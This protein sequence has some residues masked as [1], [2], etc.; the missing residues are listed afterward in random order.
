[1][2]RKFFVGGLL[3]GLILMVGGV[4]NAA[5]Q[6]ITPSQTS[7]Q[8]SS[9]DAFSFDV[10]YSNDASA[11]ASGLGL[12]MHW[13]SSKLT[14]VSLGNLLSTDKLTA[15]VG[16]VE[17]D[18]ADRDGDSATDKMIMISWVSF[19]GAW[20]ATNT[21]YTANFTVAPGLAGSTSIRFSAKNASGASTTA[22]GYTLSATDVTV[23][24]IILTHVISH[25]NAVEDMPFNFQFAAD[26]FT[27]E[28]VGDSLSYAASLSNDFP[29]PG[30]LSFEGATRTFSGT[31]A[32]VDIGPTSQKVMDVFV[33][34]TDST[35]RSTTASFQ[36]ILSNT[37]DLP[38]MTGTPETQATPGTFYSFT[39]NANDM[40][41]DAL[42]FVIEN[43]PA[44][45]NFNAG[46]GTLSGSPADEHY[47][48]TENIAIRLI[49]GTDT[50]TLPSFD[51]TVVDEVKP[52]AA[53]VEP[54]NAGLASGYFNYVPEIILTCTDNGSGCADTALYYTLDGSSP[55]DDGGSIRTQA[56][57]YS[58]PLTIPENTTTLLSFVAVDISGNVSVVQAKQYL[59]DTV[60]PTIAVTHPN[61][62]AFRRE[63]DSI[64]GTATDNLAG[65]K[66]I[67]LQVIKGELSLEML[68]SG[69][70]V[71]TEESTWV[72]VLDRSTEK[73]WSQ[74]AFFTNSGLWTTGAAY[75]VIIQVTDI[76]DNQ[77]TVTL[78]FTITDRLVVSGRFHNSESQPVSKVTVHFSGQ[79]GSPSSSV[80]SDTSGFYNHQLDLGW[81]GSVE[82]DK[83]GYTF[84]PENFIITTLEETVDTAD[85]TAEEVASEANARAIIVAGGGDPADYL[86][87]ATNSV[88]NFAYRTLRY[89]GILRDNIRYF[90]A[91]G[92]QDVDGDGNFGN[93][94]FGPPTAEALEG[95]IKDWA[96]SYVTDK[97]PLLIY[98]V[99]H[100]DL[101]TFYVSKPVGGV[102]ET[103]SASQ[104]DAWLDALQEQTGAKVIVIYDACFSGSFLDDLMPPPGARRVNIMSTDTNQLASFAS[105]GSLSFSDF[106]WK[107]IL[108]GKDLRRSFDSSRRDIR[109]ATNQVQG[110]I[111]DADGDGTWAAKQEGSLLADMYLGNPFATAAVFPE[112]IE[113]SGDIYMEAGASQ[114]VWARLQQEPSAIDTVWAV[115][116]PPGTGETGG[117]PIAD[118][119]LPQPVSLVY[120]QGRGQYE[121]TFTPATHGR[122]VLNYYAQ[123]KDSEKWKSLP[124]IATVHVGQDRF[125]NDD[126]AEQAAIITLNDNRPQ[127]HNFHQPGDEDWVTFYAVAGESYEIM[128]DHAGLNA[129]VKITLYR[130]NDGL[131]LIE[132]VDDNYGGEMELLPWI[133]THDGMYYVKIQNWVPEVTGHGTDYDL[134]IY[135]PKAPLIG[136]VTGT[137]M[138][139]ITG[140][141][142]N[143][144][145]VRSAHGA[146]AI[147]LPSGAFVMAHRSGGP[148]D[149]TATAPGYQA[150]SGS[151]TVEELAVATLNVAMFPEG[152]VPTD[153]DSDTIPDSLDNCTTTA[154]PNQ[155]NFDGDGEGD[156][157]D[158]DDDN[159]GVADT[160]DAYPL[161]ASQWQPVDTTDSDS[162]GIPDSLD[163]CTTTANP[164][165]ANF[166]GDE[167]GDACDS[168]DDND[169]VADR[170]DDY[171]QDASRWFH[172]TLISGSITGGSSG[173]VFVNVWSEHTQSWG[174][175]PIT[176]EADGSTDFTIR[177]LPEAGDYRLD[178]SSK[179][180][181]SGYYSVVT[182]GPV[183]RKE[184][185]LLNTRSGDVSG[186]QISLAAATELAVTVTGLQQGE[187]VNAGLWSDALGLGEWGEAQANANGVATL[188]IQGLNATGTDYRLFVQVA[189]GRYAVGHYKGAPT[190]TFDTDLADGDSTLML[191]GTLVDW[192]QATLIDMAYNISVK[193]AVTSGGTI[194]GTVSGLSAHQSAW[195]DAYSERTHGWGG[196]A[197]E[198]DTDGSTPYTLQGIKRA[199]DY[200]VSI[201]GDGVQ[202]GFY[203]GSTTPLASWERAARIDIKSVPEGQE[204]GDATGIDLVVSE[205]VSISGSVSGLQANEWAF[206]DAWSDS[207]FSWAGTTVEANTET[208]GASVPYTL[209]GLA[210][211]ADYELSLD[212]A[213]YV[214]QRK[215]G[216]DATT[217]V[218]GV[219]FTL[220]TGGKISGSIRGLS[221]SEFVWLDAFSPERGVWGGVGVVTDA[222][223]S[224]TYTVDGLSAASDYVVSLRT[225]GKTFF[226]K[227]D[228]VTPVWS[229]HGSVTVTSGTT[230]GIDFD[231]TSAAEMVFKLSGTVT[232]NPDSADQVVEMMAWSEEG[233]VAQVSR[234][235]GGVFTLK[236]LP[237]GDYMLEIVA[238]GYTPQRIKT[239]TVSSGAVDSSTLAW[240]NSWNGMGT[241]ALTAH[242]TGLDVT[243]SKGLT[244]SGTVKD[245]SGT[246]LPGVWVNAWNDKSAVGAGAVTDSAG[247]YT[248]EGL[249]ATSGAETYTVEVWT[250][251]GT[252]SEPHQTLT[253]DTTFD[254]QLAAK[255]SGGISGLVITSS[256][257]AKPEAL[258][259]IYDDT[260]KQVASTATDATGAFK[261]E[262][263]TPKTYTVKVFGD[264]NLSTTY[265]YGE[266]LVAVSES[267]VD[268]G[269]LELTP[270]S[271]S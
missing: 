235:G 187:T 148:Y 69:M 71:F 127:H 3:L 176:L 248:I 58:G 26:T 239:A 158:D 237:R 250:L 73:D 76:T 222:N 271:G 266:T 268:M 200:R 232:L 214:R 162:D 217:S 153:S 66:G 33:T 257:M 72:A 231:L 226:H 83:Q 93:D 59:I 40:D 43:K 12:S 87:Y 123:A 197:V 241:V 270:P 190:H 1:M 255:A 68:E 246:V 82:P 125:E 179:Q 195:I 196:V 34:A 252:V 144:A 109:Y 167:T 269:T 175:E 244:L 5:T 46:N 191:A 116:M 165:Q 78:G 122:Y 173:V 10:V 180:F 247:S 57:S 19:T 152:I 168:D 85:F 103:I 258:V 21:L 106:F 4:A 14:F 61:D 90:N 99:D 55:V 17:D 202:G 44:W 192:Q 163:N 27:D 48:T 134:E 161:D 108:Q 174:G 139:G 211:A 81:S 178:W 98:M 30:W 234:I 107:H 260:G 142:I 70:L 188:V 54:D 110:P 227:T 267:T 172:E 97:K 6:I 25:Q 124:S 225:E 154:N 245:A 210:R 215:T 20:P 89:K 151:I 16:T 159:D 218:T 56:M 9:G 209:D 143:A 265:A 131:I 193:V 207:T 203:A 126:S 80:T 84:S 213:G 185:T 137:V 52:L 145:L 28:G 39:P 147:T 23:S 117:E 45:A 94:I 2:G 115:V 166:D 181:A 102:A 105:G 51:L 119:D 67:Q 198:A 13:D 212:A 118:R 206:V 186:I 100:G 37:N 75:R 149:L 164:N 201:S 229:Q 249:S 243:L 112:I 65:I 128:V 91:Q 259:L 261:V 49:A 101:D 177:G 182:N 169:G 194:S 24:R 8:K 41:G 184:A 95:A 157:C 242:T 60:S 36:I 50:V 104:L 79:D 86:W 121:G 189:S 160:Q 130:M 136:F 64:S 221:A 53:L 204:N 135:R 140:I 236:G 88:A 18:T 141:G 74:W 129:D 155:A 35:N 156:A 42:S 224:A 38:T 251:S 223:G 62:G 32:N 208:S 240:T 138:H 31:P 146:S 133:A 205:G 63:L 77:H 15:G 253:A 220:F 22:T 150:F 132:E 183:S 233:A 47:G 11:R 199:K 228:G 120:N 114:L 254:L 170:R 263:L 262:G 96:G 111:L 216:T 7:F 92:G 230:E 113:T 219:D 238:E 264:D 256:K 29:L 171:P